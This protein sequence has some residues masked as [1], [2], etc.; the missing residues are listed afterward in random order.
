MAK[1][2]KTKMLTRY[3]VKLISR[4]IVFLSVLIFYVLKRD[5]LNEY[6][7]APFFESFKP[8]HALWIVFMGLMVIHI[9]P[10]KKIMTMALRKK[11]L[12]AYAPVENFDKEE[13]KVFVKKQNL[14]ALIVMLIWLGLN[15]VFG[16]L[17]YMGFL[18]RADL[19]MLTTTFFLCDY[20]CILFL[21][22]F[23]T[24][25]MKNRCCVNCRIYDW[26]HFMMFTPMAF[27]G[28]FFGL[29]LFYMSLLVLI[30]W[31][32]LFAIH[33]E[34]FYS[35]SNGNLKCQNCKDKTCQL[36]NKI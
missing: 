29:S 14:N 22:P 27:M 4:I 2:V 12:E 13:L 15:S 32:L 34:R 9:F 36:K 10:L 1:I 23:R 6:L 17:Y 16:V 24:F 35:G 8:T 25:I 11:H 20:I 31:E 21:C 5:T 18:I 33:P 26:G 19:Y 3:I 28:N 30:N 7:N